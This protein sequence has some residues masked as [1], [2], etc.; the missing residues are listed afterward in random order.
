MSLKSHLRLLLLLQ[1]L[2]EPVHGL[3]QFHLIFLQLL[4]FFVLLCELVDQF[5]DFRIPLRHC[6]QQRGCLL[7]V[8]FSS[9][10][11]GYAH[12]VD[13]VHLEFRFAYFCA[14]LELAGVVDRGELGDISDGLLLLHV[15]GR[16]SDELWILAGWVVRRHGFELERL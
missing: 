16:G 7:V 14:V 2:L 6:S 10:L 11:T 12:A 8:L 5:C 3:L 1:L 13:S 15:H 4:V 9:L